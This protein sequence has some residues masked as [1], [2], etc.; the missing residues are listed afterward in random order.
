LA[1]Q[2]VNRIVRDSHGFLWFCTA[3]GLSRFDGYEFA[4]FGTEQGLP[5][6]SVNDLLETRAGEY[7]LA[8]SGGLVRFD[9]DGRPGRRVVY[10]DTAITTPPMFTVVAT[11]SDDRDSQVINV[12]LEGGNGTIWAGTRAGLYRLEHPNGA[13][14]LRPVDVRMPGDFPEQRFIADLL[15]DEHGSLWIAAPS[16]LYRSWPDGSA[17][18]YTTRDGLPGDYLQDLFE[19]HQGRLWAG[20][21]LSGFF[22]FKADT[23]H[24]APLVDLAFLTDQ[25][26]SD[27]PSAW[28][29]QLFEA[30][31]LRFRVATARGLLEFFPDATEAERF[32]T[33]T[34]RNG[35]T[36]YNI[37]AVAEDLGGNLWL[38]TQSAGAMKLTRGGF[39]TYGKQDG[40]ETLNAIFEDAAGDLCFRGSVLGDTRT[41]VFEGGELDLFRGD[42]PTIHSRFGCFDGRV[43]NWFAPVAV[44][45]TLGWVGEQITLRARSGEWWIGTGEGYFARRSI[46]FSNSGRRDHLPSTR[47][48][49]AGFRAGVSALRRLARRRV[50]ILPN[51]GRLAHG[52]QTSACAT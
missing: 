4:N 35:L 33:Y 12:L 48:R 20:T 46:A 26:P 47:R 27:L 11:D 16:G 25:G 3:G 44:T 28:V 13:R 2:Q 10:E 42:Q 51:S 24:S 32:R 41:S 40:I 17:A 15:E 1:H 38:G 22:G 36:D 8:T 30:A 45:R 7:W 52:S 23:T 18:R 21:L 39:T 9:P 43:F 6:S 31:D 5:H 50:D 19:D 29:F 34:S 14:S 37:T 49:R